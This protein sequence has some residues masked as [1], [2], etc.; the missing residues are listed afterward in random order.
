MSASDSDLDISGIW[1]L[2]VAND[3]LYYEE[4]WAQCK[5]YVCYYANASGTQN[6]CLHTGTGTA[7]IG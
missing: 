2:H 7:T 4:H 6:Y 5:H 1:W 3:T